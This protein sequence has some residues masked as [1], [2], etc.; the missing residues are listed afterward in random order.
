MLCT[1]QRCVVPGHCNSFRTHMPVREEP[2]TQEPM[3]PED[4]PSHAPE[5]RAAARH[6]GRRRFLTV[7]GAAAAL[8]FAVGVPG[9]GTAAAAELDTARITDDPFTLGVASGDPHPDSVLLWTRLAPAPYQ[10]DGGLPARRVTV[11]WEIA[12]D[13]RFRSVV[14]RG[15][16]PPTPSSTTPCT[17]RPAGSPRAA[18]TTTASA[19][20]ASSA[21]RAAPAPRPPPQPRRRAHLRRRLLPA[22]RPGLLHRLPA[23]RPGGR[24]RRLPPR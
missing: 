9:A 24:R 5:L 12:L 19:R 3:T 7:T 17:S 4:R 14:R 18:S 6:I 21:P 16:P 11:E 1:R 20:A 2:M 15:R 23:P 10:A 8:A 13:A 22:L